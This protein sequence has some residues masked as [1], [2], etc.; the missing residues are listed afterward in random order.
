[1]VIIKLLQLGFYSNQIRNSP[2][3]GIFSTKKYVIIVLIYLNK[4]GFFSYLTDERRPDALVF[5][6]LSRAYYHCDLLSSSRHRLL[7]LPYTRRT[8]QR[9]Q[10]NRRSVGPALFG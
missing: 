5:T 8:T 7:N 9:W 3:R 10:S 6:R 2:I 1:M 4:E